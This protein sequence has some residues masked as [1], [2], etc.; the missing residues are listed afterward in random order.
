MTNKNLTKEQGRTQV[1]LKYNIIYWQ[2]E[3]M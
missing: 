2:K 1:Y 3:V